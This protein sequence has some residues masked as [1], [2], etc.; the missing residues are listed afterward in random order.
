MK[1]LEDNSVLRYFSFDTQWGNS[2]VVA[3]PFNIP[4]GAKHTKKGNMHLEQS[5][6]QILNV[7]IRDYDEVRV[8]TVC[9]RRRSSRLCLWRRERPKRRRSAAAGS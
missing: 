1:P 8:V 7:H 9:V 4:K 3:A 2:G 5:Y 6:R